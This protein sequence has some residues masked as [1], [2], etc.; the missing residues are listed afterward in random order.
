[1][2]LVLVAQTQQVVEGEASPL[3]TG[4]GVRLALIPGVLVFVPLQLPL[5][6]D[7]PPVPS[8]GIEE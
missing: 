6:S 2:A 3:Q 7:D 5:L 8:F 4:R 1:M